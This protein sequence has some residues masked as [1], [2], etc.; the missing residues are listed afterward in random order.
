MPTKTKPVPTSPQPAPAALTRR[1][2]SPAERVLD[3]TMPTKTK[4]V[5]TSPQPAFENL[6]VPPWSW[7]RLTANAPTP[8]PT[9]TPTP[10]EGPRDNARITH[11]EVKA[12]GR[13]VA[14]PGFVSTITIE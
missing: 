7:A 13:L 8:T 2:I 10:A 14:R 6:R 9:P 4:P 5:P 1:K 12:F 3:R 11:P